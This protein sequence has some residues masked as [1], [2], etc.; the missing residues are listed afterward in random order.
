[1]IA[2]SIREAIPHVHGEGWPFIAATLVLA[3]VL[4]FL[5]QPLFWLLLLLAGWM[6]IFFRDPVRIVPNAPGLVVSPADGRVD[7]RNTAAS[8]PCGRTL[9]LHRCAA[10]RRPKYG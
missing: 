9:W 6:A 5:F 4:G 7:H 2:R 1:M 3:V 8:T 10:L